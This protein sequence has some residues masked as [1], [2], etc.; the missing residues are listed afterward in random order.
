MWSVYALRSSTRRYIYVGLTSDLERRVRQH[1]AG[2]EKTTR[3]YRPFTLILHAEF[4]TR[5]EARK[6]EIYLKSGTGKELLHSLSPGQAM[7]LVT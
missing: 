2:R 7:H 6:R 3:P 1:N 5:A 4:S